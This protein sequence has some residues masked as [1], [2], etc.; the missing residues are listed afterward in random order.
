MMRIKAS[1]ES[2]FGGKLYKFYVYICMYLQANF[3]HTVTQIKHETYTRVRQRLHT[4][5]Q[6][7]KKQRTARGRTV[8]RYSREV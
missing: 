7:R 5:Y 8:Y 3:I 1:R 2:S 4:N 6:T